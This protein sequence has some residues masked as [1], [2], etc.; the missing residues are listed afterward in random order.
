MLACGSGTGRVDTGTS[1]ATALLQ[2][3]AA[4]VLATEC[5]VRTGI[6]S[7]LARDLTS[8]LVAHEKMGFAMRETIFKLAVEGCPLGLAFTYLGSVDAGLPQ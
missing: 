7:R 6:V 8:R 1:L 2:L 3:G 4:G 5:T